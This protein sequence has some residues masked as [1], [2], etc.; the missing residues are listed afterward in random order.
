[1]ISNLTWKLTAAEILAKTDSLNNTKKTS[2]DLIANATPATFEKVCKSIAQLEDSLASDH[3]SLT[4]LKDV[5]TDSMI[6]NASADAAEKL[7]SFDIEQSMRLDI[8]ISH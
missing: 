5:S 1:M 6:R 4:F 8:C 2:F 3:S 7:E